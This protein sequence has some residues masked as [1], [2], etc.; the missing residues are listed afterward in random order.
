MKTKQLQAVAKGVL[1]A[2]HLSAPIRGELAPGIDCYIIGPAPDDH[3]VS[4]RA[5]MAA[6]TPGRKSADL[7]PMLSRIPAQILAEVGFDPMGANIVEVPLRDAPTAH[8]YSA[9]DFVRIL[10]AYARWLASG[11]MRK[12]QQ[13]LGRNAAGVLATFASLG[14]VAAIRHACGVSDAPT[15]SH[16]PDISEIVAQVTHQGD[17]IEQLTREVSALRATPAKA[18]RT[19]RAKPPAP[20]VPA[21]PAAPFEFVTGHYLFGTLWGRDS[22]RLLQ[23]MIH[24]QDRVPLLV[25]AGKFIPDGYLDHVEREFEKT[26]PGYVIGE[27]SAGPLSSS[28]GLTAKPH[29]GKPARP[30]P[31]ALPAPTQPK[32]E[33][34]GVQFQI[35][36]AMTRKIPVRC[37]EALPENIPFLETEHEGQKYLWL[38]REAWK[39]YQAKRS[40]GSSARH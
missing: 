27:W 12:D 13:H 7:N 32:T 22:P 39:T 8:T 14:V 10:S 11:T 1:I 40:T 25:Y 20:A 28:I 23:P 36:R 4:K 5:V 26:F 31:K 19:P 9:T 29:K 18:P 15:I 6:L 35:W 16:G 17:A 24:V 34:K 38:N 21:L 37:F 2:D 33:A 3:R 30:E